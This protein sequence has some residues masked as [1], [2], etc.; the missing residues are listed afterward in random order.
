[1]FAVISPIEA[2]LA[3]AAVW[4]LVGALG[5]RRLST[6]TGAG[7]LTVI[8]ALCSVGALGLVKFSTQR[9]DAG[10]VVL[11]LV[12]LLGGAA[13][14]TAGVSCLRASIGTAGS[15]RSDPAAL[16]LALV[17]AGLS[18]AALLQHYDGYSSLASEVGEG[19]SA[20]FF[21]EP[22]FAVVLVLVG[23]VSLGSWP[24]FGV[25]VLITAGAQI[26]VHYVGV[27]LA[28]HF[29]VG[30][31]GGTGPAWF[32]GF[33]GGVLVAAAGFYAHVASRSPRAVAAA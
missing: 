25:G 11:S 28:S 5:R 26:A 17:G 19:Y 27:L 18:V 13:T 29:A 30:E 1:M 21:F 31:V 20:E 32:L 9:I 22:A 6:A 23:L 12:A 16:I 14:L 15:G 3:S 2:I 4:L 33:A 8:G 7:A 24:R 10:A